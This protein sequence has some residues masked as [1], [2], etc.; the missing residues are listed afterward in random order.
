MD[1]ELEELLKTA[2]SPHLVASAEKANELLSRLQA[3]INDLRPRVG[4][5]ELEND[6]ARN[7]IYNE[8]KD[9][10]K[11]DKYIDN[12]Y[13]ITE[14]YREWKRKEWLLSDVR[15]VRRNLERHYETLMQQQKFNPKYGN[16][17]RV[18]N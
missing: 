12:Q 11:T 16:Y 8:L 6:L 9:Q 1:K 7:K 18:I 17:N 3:V 13:R 4:E 10:G 2:A 15:A 14:L 5:M